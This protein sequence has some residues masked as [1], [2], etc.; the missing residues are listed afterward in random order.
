MR[1]ARRCSEVRSSMQLG[2]GRLSTS[3][4]RRLE[5][6]LVSLPGRTSSLSKRAVYLPNLEQ[7]DRGQLEAAAYA[8]EDQHGSAGFFPA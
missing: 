2:P 8:R 3:D 1:E 6:T 7:F 4:A 5:R